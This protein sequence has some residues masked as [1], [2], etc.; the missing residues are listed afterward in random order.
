MDYAV[1]ILLGQDLK[2]SDENRCGQPSIKEI[3]S[4]LYVALL[5]APRLPAKHHSKPRYMSYNSFTSSQALLRQ[6]NRSPPCP[7]CPLSSPSKN[8]GSLST[9][10]S[11]LAHESQKPLQRHPPRT[12]T[13]LSRKTS[14][15]IG[16][17]PNN[18][19][20][21]EL[22]GWHR[23]CQ[24]RGLVNA[25]CGE[26]VGRDEKVGSRGGGCAW[27]CAAAS[28]EIPGLT[29]PATASSEIS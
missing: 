7:T 25:V 29:S 24:R 22:C 23:Q 16:N 28:M 21:E 14:Q 18:A 12:P 4:L 1:E 19:L 6:A 17:V 20:R 27:I 8:P 2:D 26:E 11:T 15:E 13:A 10:L 5:R 9:L 3:Y